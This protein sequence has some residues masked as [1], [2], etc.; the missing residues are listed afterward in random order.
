MKKIQTAQIKAY[1]DKRNKIILGVV[2]VFLLVFST[3]G[4]SLMSSDSE[5]SLKVN[6]RGLDFFKVNG[7][8]KTVI[9]EQVFAFS[10]LPSE[11]ENVEIEGIYDIGAYSNQILYF[12]TFNEAAPEILN[13]IQRFIVRYQEACVEQE[14]CGEDLPLKDCSNNIIIYE[15]GNDTK[16]YKNESCVYLVGDALK[17]ADAFLYETLH[18]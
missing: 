2:L 1:H 4:Y 13:N 3:L 16:V 17:A 18:I 9:E 5:S 14:N 7:L 6:E 8:W 10:Y 15:A 12:V 11:V